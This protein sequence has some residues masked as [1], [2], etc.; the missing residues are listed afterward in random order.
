MSIDPSSIH[1]IDGWFTGILRIARQDEFDEV[2]F[3]MSTRSLGRGPFTYESDW[4]HEEFS[5]L[6]GDGVACGGVVALAAPQF[7]MIPARRIPH[8]VLYVGQAFGKKGER[9]AF[10][11]LRSHSTLQK[12]YAEKS[13]DKEIWLHL[14][15]VSDINLMM[16]FNPQIPTQTTDEEDEEHR[17]RALR[18]IHSAGFAQQE[19][20]AIGEAGLIRYFQPKY[21]EKLRNN[22][23]DPKHVHI[24]TCYDLDLATIVVELQGQETRSFFYSPV[25]EKPGALHICR[26]PLYET[27]GFIVDWHGSRPGQAV[28]TEASEP[29]VHGCAGSAKA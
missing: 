13:P 29:N 24:S 16:E 26:Y 20:I 21:N 7:G 14:C 17:N 15:K 12:I 27:A 28:E 4:P 9:T 1:L 6:D 8:E 10:D 11:R 18:R 23:P 2:P 25:A 3:S 19:A 22:Y 5:I